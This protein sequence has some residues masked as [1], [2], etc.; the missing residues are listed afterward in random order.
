MKT[1]LKIQE[2]NEKIRKEIVSTN[3]VVN[4][5]DVG[6]YGS[7]HTVHHSSAY[8][9]ND[10]GTSG[11]Y[12]YYPNHHHHHHVH[13]HHLQNADLLSG[14]ASHNGIPT[15]NTT[16][17]STSSNSSAMYHPHLYSPGAAEYGITTSNHSPSDHSAYYD[18]ENAV[19]QSYYP[20]QTN[21]NDQ[22]QQQQQP[23]ATPTQATT[24][25]Q[26]SIPVSSNSNVI[27]DSHIIS[28]DNGLSYTNL[29]YMYGANHTGSMY[30]HGDEK[31]VLSH[32][33][34]NS[35]G[36]VD[37]TAVLHSP[38]HHQGPNPMNSVATS[39]GGWQSHH[40]PQT[41]A[42]FID[43]SLTAHQIGLS[44]MTCLQR[45]AQM[46]ALNGGNGVRTL[47][48]QPEQT[49]LLHAAQQSQHQHH[50][51]TQQQ[52]QQTQQQPTYKWMQV[53]RNVP[54]P[55]GKITRR[56]FQV[57]IRMK[58]DV[59]FVTQ[60]SMRYV[61]RVNV[62]RAETMENYNLVCFVY[63]PLIALN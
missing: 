21:A 3:S 50:H 60:V 47:H 48:N 55:Q 18:S 42:G 24:P 35:Q 19:L 59:A 58:K 30:L 4:M 32:L 61:H 27:S 8:Q 33:P 28:S 37:G 23:A 26:Q 6:M 57:T 51:Q 63:F 29:D 2:E 22:Q 38:Q 13:H 44:P 34:Y 43:G 46:N 17:T 15:P 39:T 31:P 16:P 7:D 9:S 54:K 49:Q 20:N 53:K 11:G 56:N 52:T 41:N 36:S 25:L 40:L 10:M 12:A 62:A 45:P 14:Y 5:M 1:Q